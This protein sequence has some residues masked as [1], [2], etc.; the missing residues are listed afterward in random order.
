MFSELD[1]TDEAHCLCITNAKTV[2]TGVWWNERGAG[3]WGV[4]IMSPPSYFS[5]TLLIGKTD[6]EEQNQ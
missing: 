6:I 2:F 5:V 4:P 3:E 1:E